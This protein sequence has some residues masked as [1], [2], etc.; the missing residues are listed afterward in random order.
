M[1][2]PHADAADF[3][4]GSGVVGIAE[5]L[6]R[7]AVDFNEFSAGIAGEALGRGEGEFAAEAVLQESEADDPDGRIFGVFGKD[8]LETAEDGGIIVVVPA[9]EWLGV[10][11]FG[12]ARCEGEEEE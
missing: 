1:R 3:V 6:P 5:V 12:A 11:L 10:T 7:G 4:P 2:V 8:A 9:G